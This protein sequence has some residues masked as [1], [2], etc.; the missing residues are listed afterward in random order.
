MSIKAADVVFQ[1]GSKQSFTDNVSKLLDGRL[2]NFC[3]AASDP[4]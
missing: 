2:S 3:T 1:D 4:H